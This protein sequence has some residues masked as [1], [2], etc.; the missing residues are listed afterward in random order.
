MEARGGGVQVR[1]TVYPWRGQRR[2][3]SASLSLFARH[4]LWMEKETPPNK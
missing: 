2:E 4:N 3:S 1:R